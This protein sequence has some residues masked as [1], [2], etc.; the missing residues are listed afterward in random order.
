[1]QLGFEISNF[2]NYTKYTY[3]ESSLYNCPCVNAKIPQLR[4][5]NTLVPSYKLL[6]EPMLTKF[7][8]AILRH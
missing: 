6:R 5:V 7:Y 3:F 8:E 4:L 1:M 2:K